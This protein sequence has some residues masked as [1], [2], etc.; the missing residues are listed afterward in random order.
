MILDAQYTD[1]E[2]TA[3]VGWV[4]STTSYATDIGILGKV[5]RLARFHHDPVRG[6]EE[7]DAIVSTACKRAAMFG[8]KVQIFGAAEGMT[9]Q[10]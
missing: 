9:V 1:N 4:H 2:Y 6:D 8:S 3:K 10:L 5:A 7:L